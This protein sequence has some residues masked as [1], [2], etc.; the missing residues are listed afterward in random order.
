MIFQKPVH[1]NLLEIKSERGGGTL[2]YAKWEKEV[3]SAEN[4]SFLVILIY[5][6]AAKLLVY[7]GI[8][9]YSVTDESKIIKFNFCAWALEFCLPISWP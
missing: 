3:V 2:V 8:L 7:T 4:C 1:P 6:G 5:S 9:Q